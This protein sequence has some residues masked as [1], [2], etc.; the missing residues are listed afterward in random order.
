MDI[1]KE[2]VKIRE[3][4]EKAALATIISR[5]GSTPQ[6]ESAKMLIREDG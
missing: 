1:Y 6:K 2:I 5:K 3:R 4:G